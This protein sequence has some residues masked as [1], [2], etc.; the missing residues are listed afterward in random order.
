M[1]AGSAFGWLAPAGPCTQQ[2]R[3]VTT[4]LHQAASSLLRRCS[5]EVD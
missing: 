5:G 2:Q 3:N 4:L 1:P